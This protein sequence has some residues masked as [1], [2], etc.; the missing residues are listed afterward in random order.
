MLKKAAFKV[1]PYLI[2][3]A[4]LAVAALV[5]THFKAENLL[6]IGEQEIS[7]SDISNDSTTVYTGKKAG[8]DIPRITDA[9]SFLSGASPQ[10]ITVE[11][12]DAVATGIYA[13]KQWED[14]AQYQSRKRGRRYT[15]TYIG[16]RPQI[17]DNPSHA[18]EYY[19]EYY[20]ICLPNGSWIPALFDNN[21]ASKIQQGQ[22]VTL[23][24]GSRVFT[25]NAFSW[26]SPICEQ[27]KTS[28]EYAL[29]CF[30]DQWYQQNHFWNLAIR[31]V[32]AA[33]CFFAL[34]VP[35]IMLSDRLLAGSKEK[36]TERREP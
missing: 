1:M 27:Y 22:S 29:Y 16:E 13:H 28:A 19:N 8:A 7:L 24:I 5:F 20:L 36:T 23:P 12:I 32:A 17:T 2:V 10:Y 30:D 15:K 33:I 11:P 26:L 25:G 6:R 35:G 4:S 34:A 9:E 18:L 3:L 14:T 31:V 21:Y